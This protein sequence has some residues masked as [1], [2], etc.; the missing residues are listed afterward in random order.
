MLQPAT[1]P[2]TADAA[3]RGLAGVVR[4]DPS[5]W[6]RLSIVVALAS[7]VGSLLGLIDYG[8]YYGA[9]AEVFIFCRPQGYEFSGTIQVDLGFTVDGWR[10]LSRHLRSMRSFP[11]AGYLRCRPDPGGA[12][13]DRAILRA[14]FGV[15]APA[16]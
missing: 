2:T 1:E 10:V 12:D 9:E 16:G 6:L 13:D 8:Q 15:P 14:C 11:L 4:R 7:A 3:R 5:P